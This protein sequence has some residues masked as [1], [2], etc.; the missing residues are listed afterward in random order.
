MK[1]VDCRSGFFQG[2]FFSGITTK[3]YLILPLA[4]PIPSRKFQKNPLVSFSDILP[5]DEQ[6][7]RCIENTRMVQ[8]PATAAIQYVA[9]CCITRTGTITKIVPGCLCP[10]PPSS[11]LIRTV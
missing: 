6:K 4:T 8:L 9:A 5:T 2:S 7:E 3:M 10:F 11:M 1:E